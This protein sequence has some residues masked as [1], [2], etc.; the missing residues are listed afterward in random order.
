MDAAFLFMS[1]EV[2]VILAIIILVIFTL[3]YVYKTYKIITGGTIQSNLMDLGITFSFL[4]L[5]SM[6]FWY[7]AI[8]G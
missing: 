6:L 8:K 4:L 2:V 1:P 7:F 3:V 5:D